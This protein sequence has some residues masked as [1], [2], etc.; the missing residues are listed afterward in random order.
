MF[1]YRLLEVPN[2]SVFDDIVMQISNTH[3]SNLNIDYV[4]ENL[5]NPTDDD[6]AILEIYL[7]YYQYRVIYDI[8]TY[9]SE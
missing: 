3:P 1:D 7:E 5:D 6:I 9:L 2:T 8:R 4:T